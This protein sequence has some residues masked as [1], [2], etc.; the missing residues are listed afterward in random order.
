MQH[1]LSSTFNH[2]QTTNESYLSNI[3]P[4]MQCHVPEGPARL[5]MNEFGVFCCRCS[6]AISIGRDP[7]CDRSRGQKR[8]FYELFNFLIYRWANDNN[9]LERINN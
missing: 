5:T 9:G 1:P 6:G 3:A 8:A 7:T 4:M 2:N